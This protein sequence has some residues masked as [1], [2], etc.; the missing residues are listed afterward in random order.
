MSV[1][2]Q[3]AI[4]CADPAALAEFWAEVL[5][6]ALPDP[7]G[8]FDTWPDFLT[9]NGVPEEDWNMAS[10][11]EDPDGD[12]PCRRVSASARD[13]VVIGTLDVVWLD[14]MSGRWDVAGMDGFELS[15][16]R[17]T[18]RPWHPSEA[19]VLLDIRSRPEVARWL[20]DPEPWADL[21]QAHG[22]LRRW[23][24]AASAAVPSSCAIVPR[25]TGIPVGTVTLTHPP[26]PGAGEV[27]RADADWFDDLG[28]S[29]D[30]VEVGW[31]L[32]PDHA[33]N[34]WATEAARSMLDHGLANGIPRVWAMMWPDNGPS[35]AVCRRLGMDPLGVRVDPWYGTAEFPD[36]RFFLTD[37]A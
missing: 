27:R 1:T 20:E 19:D 16:A 29:D 22:H 8:E 32:H 12:G 37:A 31:Y 34:G 28:V 33:G 6:Y 10:A 3:I 7:P 15:T 4:D 13:A 26:V 23:A 21:D 35:A 25:D 2:V 18:I 5:G 17:A 30:E 9:A 24:D 14:G 11:I 36:S